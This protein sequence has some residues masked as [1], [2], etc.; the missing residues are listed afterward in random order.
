MPPRKKKQQVINP[1]IAQVNYD[2]Y[3]FQV[4]EHVSPV[5]VNSLSQ[6]YNDALQYS[7]QELNDTSERFNVFKKLLS[8]VKLWDDDEI[9]EETT[10]FMRDVPWLRDVLRQI[11]VAQVHIMLSARAD[12][13]ISEPKFAFEMPSEETIVYTILTRAAKSVRSRPRLFDHALDE[14]QIQTNF[15]EIEEL[16]RKSLKRTV[17]TLVPIDEIAKAQFG[18]EPTPAAPAPEPEGEPEVEVKKK[19]KDK[20]EG[21]TEGNPEGKTDAGNRGPLSKAEVRDIEDEKA[22]LEEQEQAAEQKRRDVEDHR[23][24]KMKLLPSE[25]PVDVANED[26]I[27]ELMERV[28]SMDRGDPERKALKKRLR[29]LMRV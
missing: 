18:A 12:Q 26:E 11:I 2:T 5:I 7:D 21:K 3:T 17:I 14:E 22:E 6:I 25:V 1:Q 10:E 20:S 19:A 16:V 23:T 13:Y 8:D 15:D 4:L 29:V 28:Q 9:A 27:E 24:E